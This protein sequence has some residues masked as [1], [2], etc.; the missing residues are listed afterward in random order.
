MVVLAGD[1][2]LCLSK[3]REIIADSNPLSKPNLIISRSSK[4]TLPEKSENCVF[5]MSEYQKK[6]ADFVFDYIKPYETSRLS[7]VLG[8]YAKYSD[9]VP[10][11]EFKD[12]KNS[13]YTVLAYDLSLF[14]ATVAPYI[15][16]GIADRPEYM[17]ANLNVFEFADSILE[18][19]V[20]TILTK[21]KSVFQDTDE[22][23]FWVL[24]NSIGVCLDILSGNTAGI[25]SYRLNKYRPIAKR[26]GYENLIKFKNFVLESI[27][28]SRAQGNFYERIKPLAELYDL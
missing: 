22:S 21:Y 24:E 23:F 9:L 13:Q 14:F 10:T 17:S 16:S 27:E 6:G 4:D 1:E 11:S 18:G 12:L 2:Y 26:L 8:P 5:I 15:D 20:K 25:H 3:Y 28:S 7:S 19:D